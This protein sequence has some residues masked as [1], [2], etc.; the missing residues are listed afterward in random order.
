[1]SR[2]FQ[3]DGSENSNQRKGIMLTP[4]KMLSKANNWLADW[5][6]SGHDKETA[7]ILRGYVEQLVKMNKDSIRA[8]SFLLAAHEL[9]VEAGG[10]LTCDTIEPRHSGFNI[11]TS[12]RAAD[13]LNRAVL[14]AKD[15][16]SKGVQNEPSLKKV[17]ENLNDQADQYTKDSTLSREDMD[18]P[19]GSWKEQ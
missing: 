2:N 18:R 8:C 19:V 17:I 1:M 10:G 4:E 12:G 9:A 7:M 14:M 11:G 15:V 6:G 5:N 3:R 16:V 13:M